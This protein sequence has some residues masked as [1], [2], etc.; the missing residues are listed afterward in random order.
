MSEPST[1]FAALL[2]TYLTKPESPAEDKAPK[3][4]RMWLELDRRKRHGYISAPD[5]REFGAELRNLSPDWLAKTYPT[6]KPG[7]F[8]ERK[9]G[10]PLVWPSTAQCTLQ[11]AGVLYFEWYNQ[12][13][14]IISSPL[15]FFGAPVIEGCNESLNLRLEDGRLLYGD[16]AP[17]LAPFC[18]FHGSGRYG[19]IFAGS[20]VV[21]RGFS[22]LCHEE[23]PSNDLPPH[24]PLLWKDEG[25][26][27]RLNVV[28]TSEWDSHQCYLISHEKVP[29]P[30][31]L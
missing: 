5:Q 30:K 26:Y 12:P 21:L 7:L 17:D 8:L 1:D 28:V 2:A 10:L 23:P 9:N 13:P 11:S 22:E 29:V 25:F 18:D 31:P 19:I 3:I 15:S 14:E 16:P 6:I 24:R 27:E 4:V 20:L